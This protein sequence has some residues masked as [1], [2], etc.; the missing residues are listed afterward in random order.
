MESEISEE[1]RPLFTHLDGVVDDVMIKFDRASRCTV[2]KCP[3]YLRL[4]YIGSRGE[5]FAKSITTAVGKCY[6][7]AAIRVIFRLVLHLFQCVETS[8][9]PTTLTQLYI[10]IHATAS[11]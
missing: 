7:S 1:R 3:I 5:R 2:N 9:L 6:F 10:N 8:Y 11:N 4:P